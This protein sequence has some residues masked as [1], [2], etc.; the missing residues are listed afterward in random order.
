MLNKPK[1]IDDYM[2]DM[3]KDQ[4]DH[5]MRSSYYLITKNFT[6]TINKFI[7]FKKDA[8]T[9]EIAYGIGQR[10]KFINILIKYF[11]S[12]EEYE[13][14]NKLMKLKKLVIESGD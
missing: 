7:V 13:K 9:V 6:R 2:E 1:N 12:T 14:C 8:D 4:K 5:I 11:E 3:V 10:S